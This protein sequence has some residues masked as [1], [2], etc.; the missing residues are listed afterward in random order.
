MNYKNQQI[1]GFVSVLIVAILFMAI[2]FMISQNGS[3]AGR[4]VVVVVLSAI[5][6]ILG[7]TIAVWTIKKTTRQ[8]KQV[9][10]VME[11]MDFN[12][13]EHL[14]RLQVVTGDEIGNIAVAFNKMSGA[15]ED[16][17]RKAREFNE[18]IEESNWIQTQLAKMGTVYQNINE[19]DDLAN[20]FIRELTPIV[21]S[22]YGIFY[23]CEEKNGIPMLMHKASYSTYHAM[24]DA[25]RQFQF[26][27]GVVGQA[28]VEQTIMLMES[29][30]DHP[31]RI[32]TGATSIPLKQIMLLPILFENRTVVVIELGSIYGFSDKQQ[33]LIEHVA[34]TFGVVVN[35]VDNRMQVDRLLREAQT[36]TEELQSQ[37]EELQAQQEELQ[38]TNE[39]LRERN[40][41]S[42]IKTEE[43]QIAQKE[44][45]LYSEELSR[46]SQ[47]KSEFLANMSHELRTPLNSIL[48]LS[49]LISEK[50]KTHEEDDT[51]HFGEVIHHSGQD[52]LNLIDDILD[53]SKVEAGMVEVQR[54]SVS[55]Y[56]L[57]EVMGYSFA[58]I[59]EQKGIEFQSYIAENV[60]NVFYTDEKRL[61]QILKNLLSNAFKFT[62]KGSVAINIGLADDS[63]VAKGYNVPEQMDYMLAISVTDTGIGIK[64]DKQ[65]LIFE[66]FQQEDGTTER[67]YGG[68]G[69]GL[70]ICREFSKLLGGYVTVQSEL[71]KGST[72]TLY[73]PSL[74]INEE[75]QPVTKPL[76]LT[77]MDQEEQQDS[78][79]RLQGKSVLVVD[80]DLRN[81]FALEGVLKGKGMHVRSAQN[82][83]EAIALLN[84]ESADIVLMDMMM[85]IMDGYEAMRWIRMEEKWKNLP[86]IALTAKAMKDDRELC[87]EAGASDYI[88]KPMNVEQLLSVILVWLSDWEHPQR[89]YNQNQKQQQ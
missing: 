89:L 35:N 41:Y 45:Q 68:T 37:Q 7:I 22:A 69:L 29:P 51:P 25:M 55:V 31:I 60:P 76:P 49:Q 17:N 78:L 47:Y 3:F 75:G 48:I 63:M 73:L 64:E 87:I 16:H 21:D 86:I 43:L 54:D 85:P 40:H 23:F 42:E 74:A 27:E 53:L 18:Q 6:I 9:T 50:D 72:F 46:S 12:T 66:A 67:Q 1:F 59:A 28:A 81:I 19:I 70:S 26:G 24:P 14:P 80:D 65:N 36:L 62:S 5:L 84:A 4:G 57:P 30:S 10:T 56:D 34:S 20:R 2:E 8:L 13:A 83:E 44:L 38:A 71:G 79:A 88:S 77:W 61:Q 32:Q 33:K 82:G 15:L 58:K 52:L 11:E 39:Q